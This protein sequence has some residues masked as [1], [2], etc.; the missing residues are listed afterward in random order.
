MVSIAWR[1]FVRFEETIPSTSVNLRQIELPESNG[2]VAGFSGACLVPAS[3]DIL[4]TASLEDT[5]NVIDDGP[6]LGSFLGK[7]HYSRYPDKKPVTV[8][9]T[10][11]GN[12]YPGKIESIAI[13]KVISEN[14]IEALVV[15][16]NDEGPS[17]LL[18]VR[19]GW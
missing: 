5:P 6:S 7:I 3:N 10:I 13:E 9:V 8:R 14:E 16:D 2:I 15:T 17:E 18:R 11:D 1:E 19:V 12:L 4:F